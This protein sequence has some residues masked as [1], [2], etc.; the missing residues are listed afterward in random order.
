M[1]ARLRGHCVEAARLAVPG[2][3]YQLLAQDQEPGGACCAHQID[4]LHYGPKPIRASR[5]TPV[6]NTV[7]ASSTRASAKRS[8]DMMR[9]VPID[10]H[11]KRLP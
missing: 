1:R 10:L 6:R 2:R 3:P 4:R 5:G 9:D 7:A 11:Q 8:A